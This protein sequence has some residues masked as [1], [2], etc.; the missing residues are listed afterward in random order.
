MPRIFEEDTIVVG[1]GGVSVGI[2]PDF[3]EGAGSDANT[4]TVTPSV[5]LASPIRLTGGFTVTPT[6]A[7][8]SVE[9]TE[10]G[11]TV[12]PTVDG[13]ALGAP[14][15]QSVGT[16]QSA[17][18]G[19]SIVIPKPSDLLVGELMLAFV[20]QAGLGN[21]ATPTG[22]TAIRRTQRDGTLD[23]IIESFW[24]IAD[25]SDVAASDFTFTS[26]TNN[27]Y[28]GCIHRISATDPTTPINADNQSNGS[29]VDPV[30][31]SLTST[32]VNCLFVIACC[33]AQATDESFTAPTNY[34]ERTDQTGLGALGAH[35]IDTST[36]TRAQAA[37]GA[38][39]A[40]TFNSTAALAADYATQ[41]IAIAPGTL[42]LTP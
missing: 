36:A 22:W 41:A 13:T 1:G 25:S 31:T 27:G 9:I 3:G 29:A 24:K 17:S 14:F 32:A 7:M 26:D 35:V 11:F 2:G 19:T 20:M 40:Q 34:L 8:P 33:Q 42:D 28:T 38:N 10:L 23:C 6:A 39:G 21:V 15:W 37:A 30:T 12:T 16:V 18:S 4:F 5:A